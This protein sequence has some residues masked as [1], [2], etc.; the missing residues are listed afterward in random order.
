MGI[1]KI[2]PNVMHTPHIRPKDETHKMLHRHNHLRED[3]YVRST[4]SEQDENMR[5]KAESARISDMNKVNREGLNAP[6]P[7]VHY[8]EGSYKG[9][10]L[11]HNKI[12]GKIFDV[13]V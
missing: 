7:N 9:S 6:A 5:I 11:Y 10:S 8:Y 2:G 4:I 13:V 3:S 12:G 1:D